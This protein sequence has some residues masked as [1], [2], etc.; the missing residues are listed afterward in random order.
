MYPFHDQEHDII[1]EME[2]SWK[3]VI[4]QRYIIF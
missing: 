4:F 2:K 3:A 1:S